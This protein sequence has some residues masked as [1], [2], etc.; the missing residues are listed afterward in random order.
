MSEF[1]WRRLTEEHERAPERDSRD[2]LA[3]LA[4]MDADPEERELALDAD[5]LL[6][7]R[8]LPEEKTGPVD[9]EA[10]KSAVAS[11]RMA[12]DSMSRAD[13]MQRSP[14]RR[15]WAS[16]GSLAALLALAL[17]I[18]GMV[19]ID[20]PPTSETDLPTWT[21]ARLEEPA[22]LAAIPAEVAELPLVEEV[23][24]EIGPWMQIED[25][26]LSL[27]VVMSPGGDLPPDDEA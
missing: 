5:P 12:K 17:T 16:R 6:L 26:G 27:V 21:Q 7:F 19:G 15:E 11:L 4:A 9:I 18:A 22:A 2:W 25:E 8:R 3:A 23:D 1:D 20:R 13:E 10:M 14:V 24:P